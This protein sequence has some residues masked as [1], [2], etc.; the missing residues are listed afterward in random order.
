MKACLEEKHLNFYITTKT[1]NPIYNLIKMKIYMKN[2]NE[3]NITHPTF[4]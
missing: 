3:L 2:A 4:D 1:K